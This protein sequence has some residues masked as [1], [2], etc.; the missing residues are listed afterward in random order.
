MKLLHEH[1]LPATIYRV[2]QTEK[3]L[4]ELESKVNTLT[5]LIASLRSDSMVS[6]EIAKEIVP[7]FD[8]PKE[9]MMTRSARNGRKR[10]NRKHDVVKKRWAFWKTQYEAGLTLSEIARQWG[11]DHGSILYARDRKWNPSKH[12]PPA[13]V[14]EKLREY[15]ENK[16]G[17]N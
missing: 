2:G 3:R 11:C 5:Q 13:H 9:L 15:H 1:A 17:R 8:I 6:K 4:N 7:Q 16:S 10:G 14:M 12:I